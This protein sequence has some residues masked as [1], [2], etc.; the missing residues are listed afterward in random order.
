MTGGVVGSRAGVGKGNTADVAKILGTGVRV[1]GNPDT[2]VGVAEV[3]TDD[4]ARRSDADAIVR[5]LVTD[6]VVAN[7]RSGPRVSV[8][9]VA[10]GEPRRGS[11]I[12][13]RG[14][15]QVGG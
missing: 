14:G 9:D 6:A 8:E 15:H 1:G 10:V 3:K 2:G 13:T 12:S 7:G 4:V 11:G 5:D